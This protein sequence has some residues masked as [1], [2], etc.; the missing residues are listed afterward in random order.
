MQ[1]QAILYVTITQDF[2]HYT[3]VTIMIMYHVQI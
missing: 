2:H 1:S 3:D